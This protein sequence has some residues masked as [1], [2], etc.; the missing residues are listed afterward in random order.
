MA[1]FTWGDVVA[2]F[3]LLI[4]TFLVVSNWKG[5]NA[6]LSTGLSGTTGLVK[7]LQGR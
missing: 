4:F 2:G 7:T 1:K 5:S 3:V 6:L